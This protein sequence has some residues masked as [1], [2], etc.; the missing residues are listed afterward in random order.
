MPPPA[1]A[2]TAASSV[3]VGGSS[4]CPLH[5]APARARAPGRD[6]AGGVSS[7]G[8]TKCSGGRD[9]SHAAAAN[10]SAHAKGTSDGEARYGR[11]TRP[12]AQHR[13]TEAYAQ[14][15]ATAG[16]A[17]FTR[18]TLF[19]HAAEFPDLWYGIWT[20]P[21]SYFGPDAERPGEADAHVATA[22][23]DYP[24]LNAHIHTSPLRALMGILGIRGTRDGIAIAPHVPTDTFH[25][26]FPRLSLRSTPAR[27]DGTYTPVNG[28]AIV[29]RVRLTPALA[30]ASALSVDVDGA[31]VAATRDGDD[32][33]FTADSAA[34]TELAWTVAPAP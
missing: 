24:A 16:W 7:S 29:F 5:A 27:I 9:S 22:L 19:T 8:A 30:A 15:D 23:T 10:R 3:G 34:D 25:V 2:A 14:R 33:V 31:P 20:G 6:G 13:T 18:N 11:D 12:A 26:V 32:V 28:G 1:A 21:D 4:E 17:S